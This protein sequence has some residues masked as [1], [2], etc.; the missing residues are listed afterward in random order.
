MS[1]SKSQPGQPFSDVAGRLIRQGGPPL[2]RQV[3]DIIREK[4]MRREL[5]IG[6]PLPPYRDLG[7]ICDVSEITVRRAIA[8]LVAEGLLVSQRGSGTYILKSPSESPAIRNRSRKAAGGDGESAESDI[9]RSTLPVGIVV[10]S[11]TDGYPFMSQVIH[12]VRQGL[13]EAH[14]L[15]FFEQPPFT[16]LT[17]LPLDR[18]AGVLIHSPVNLQLVVRCQQLGLP[19]V[20][21]HNDL[22]DSFSHCTLIDYAQAMLLAISHLNDRGR[23][24]IA[25]VTAATNR[26]STPKMMAGYWM[27]L[28]HLGLDAPSLPIVHGGYGEDH[29]YE[30]THQLLEQPTPPDAIVYASDYQA[31]G[32][33]RAAG[34]R[35]MRVPDD[36][37]IIGSG[38]ILGT[39]VTPIEITTIDPH[40]DRIGKTGATVLRQLIEGKQSEP[41]CHVVAPE[42]IVKQSS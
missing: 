34:E 22:S 23:K 18:L 20:L 16:S 11:L 8:D 41:F 21:M 14:A 24:R 42:L 9:D 30:S 19:Y 5:A 3:G 31:R 6:D 17:S 4:V 1:E 26:F 25:M 36:L 10:T 32:G 15:Q 28:T 40:Y 39:N 2:Y 38:N 7:K 37:A 13:G 29:G 33:L 35:N 27:A 12:G